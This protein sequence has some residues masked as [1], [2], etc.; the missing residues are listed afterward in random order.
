MKTT[1]AA[2]ETIQYRFPEGFWWGSAASATQ[3]E[4][5]ANEDGKGKNIWD[6]WFELEPHRFFN[7][8]GPE[9][10]SQFYYRYR[11]D[12]KLMKEIGHNSF[13]F[14]ISWSR[15][16]PDGK[17]INKKGIDFYNHVIDELIA[18]GIE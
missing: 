13:R 15:M 4:G 2:K 10:T 3:T 14:S 7:G 12:I 5:A 9:K 16:F 17:T 8:V 1:D 11:E 18:N 6:H